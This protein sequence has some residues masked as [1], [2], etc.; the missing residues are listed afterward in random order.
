MAT[1]IRTFFAG[2]G[3]TFAILAVGFG[4]GILLARTAM[5]PE[6]VSTT[7]TA[8]HKEEPPV[9]VVLPASNEPAQPPQISSAPA[10]VP[11]ASPLGAQQSAGPQPVQDVR[12][13]SVE[14]LD[15]TEK[16]EKADTKEAEAD[17][18]D[19]KR[20]Y[21]ERKARRQAEARARHQR[22]QR[23]REQTRE[24]GILAFGDDDEAPRRGGGFFGN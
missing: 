13:Q 5:A 2:V 9:R 20:R 7:R 3:T 22:E 15:R 6:P 18:R 23:P 1:S 17:E 11:P 24:P 21:A 12:Q 8:A 14:K 19:R 4:G 10:A 16:I